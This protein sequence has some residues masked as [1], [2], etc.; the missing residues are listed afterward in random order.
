MSLAF[1]E[2]RG[3]AIAEVIE[4]LARLRIEVFRDWPYLYDGD[5]DYERRYLAGYAQGD[6]ILVAAFEGSAMV[7]ASTGMP[8]S[9]HADDFAGAFADFTHDLSSVYYCAESVLLSEFRG[10]GAYREFFA[11][12]EA[13]AQRLA[14]SFTTFCGV[15]RP[16]DHP[17][18]PSDAQ[19]LDPVWR[20]FGYAP[21]QGAVARFRWR[22]IGET[23]QTE[24][25]LQFWIKR[26]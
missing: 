1:R 5:L 8:L 14:F 13:Q 19:S 12:R 26:L 10:Q 23:A 18:R 20:R 21:L 17:L 7:G 4:P 15:I 2:Y 16:D 3:A 6:A 9:D 22:D 24:K 11:R 25:H